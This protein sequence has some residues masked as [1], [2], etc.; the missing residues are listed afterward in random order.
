MHFQV[1]MPENGR[2]NIVRNKEITNKVSLM[3]FDD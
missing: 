2:K 1:E 3:F